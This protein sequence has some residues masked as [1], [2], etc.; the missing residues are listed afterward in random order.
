MVFD[1]ATTGTTKITDTPPVK[2]WNDLMTKQYY[3]TSFKV[4]IESTRIMITYH[5]S[6]T[7]HYGLSCVSSLP[8]QQERWNPESHSPFH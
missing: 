7:L 2:A 4:K 6:G 1:V 8:Q 3:E 5:V